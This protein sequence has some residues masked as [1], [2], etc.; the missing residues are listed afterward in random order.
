[1]LDA[2]RE[3]LVDGWRLSMWFG[4]A[5]AGAVFVYLVV[6]GPKGSLL[7]VEA[8]SEAEADPEFVLAG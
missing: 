8:D 4:V 7:A 6:R 3:A 1:V 5:L 2:A